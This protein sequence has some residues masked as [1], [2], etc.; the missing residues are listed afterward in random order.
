MASKVLTLITNRVELGIMN[1]FSPLQQQR[2]VLGGLIRAMIVL[3]NK[4]S[5][6]EYRR[7]LADL[8]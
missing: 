5:E 2:Y 6:R 1:D 3:D 8:D 7:R 4:E